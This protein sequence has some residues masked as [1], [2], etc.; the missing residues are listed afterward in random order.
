[1][2]ARDQITLAGLG[3][4]PAGTAITLVASRAGYAV[5]AGPADRVRWLHTHTGQFYLFPTPDRAVAVLNACGIR[6]F[7]I[8]LTGGTP[9]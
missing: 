2:D 9:Q 5:A 1:M 4:L 6:R 3:Q 8:D 7:V